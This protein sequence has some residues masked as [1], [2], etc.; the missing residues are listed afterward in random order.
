MVEKEE[1]VEFFAGRVRNVCCAGNGNTRPLADGQEAFP[2]RE[3]GLV[4]F[5]EKLIQARAIRAEIKGRGIPIGADGVNLLIGSIGSGEHSTAIQGLGD[6]TD[7]VHAESVNSAVHPPVHHL[8]DRLAK[9]G[10]FP[11]EVGL[12][13][14]ELMEVVF[15]ALR[16]I[17][18]RGS[19][20]I[21]PPA[22]GFGSDLAG[23]M[24]F[25]CGH[26]PIPVCFVAGFVTGF[27]EP[28]VLIRGVIDHQ[29]HDDFQTQAVGSAEQ[30]IHV[31]ESAE[32][33]VDVL[34]VGNVVAVIVLGR[35]VH[36]AQPNYVNAKFCHIGQALGDSLD[37]TDSVA[38]CVLKGAR[39]NLVD[40]SVRPPRGLRR[41][42]ASR[43]EI[44]I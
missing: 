32:H 14:R 39:I 22:I 35:Y 31:I 28:R 4:H 8:V 26:P 38:V 23:D 11:I 10:S 5:M 29:I 21:A 40:H 7:D 24:P 17:G 3:D 30:F 2:T 9:F 16:I 13:G 6:L 12:L 34:V 1:H 41:S 18:P 19:T 33:G 42:V 37:I 44:S 25:L 36:G 27:D 20:K 43:S 15:T